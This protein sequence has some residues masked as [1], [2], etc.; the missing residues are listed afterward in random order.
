MPAK[1]RKPRR[2][3]TDAEKA[4]ALAALDA[5]GGNVRHTA[6]QLD[7][8][9][10]SLR[11]WSK[12]RNG[13]PGADLCAQKK[14]ELGEGLEDLARQ[15]IGGLSD[16]AKIKATK[17]TDLAVALGIAVDKMRLVRDQAT[18]I[19]GH[20]DLTPEQRLDRLGELF[21]LAESRRAAG[22]RPA[23]DGAPPPV[24]PVPGDAPGAGLP[25]PGR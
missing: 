23:V 18:Q 21:R 8:P 12:G 4:S 1:K 20:E 7:I 3:Y 11:E 10:T 6:R 13:P 2:E 5:N 16:P 14:K 9:E 19:S 17:L 15:L 24:G 22:V 25:Q